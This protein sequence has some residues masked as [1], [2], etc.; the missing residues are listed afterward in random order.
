[1]LWLVG[2]HACGL[3]SPTR[4]RTS[5]PGTRKVH[6]LDHQRSLEISVFESTNLR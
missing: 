4:D 3:S 1:M 2:P 6:T 5:T